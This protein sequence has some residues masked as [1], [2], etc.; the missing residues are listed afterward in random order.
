MRAHERRNDGR[1]QRQFMKERAS[2][3]PPFLV[4]TRLEGSTTSEGTRSSS[5]FA[6]RSGFFT[7]HFGL[8]H[9]FYSLP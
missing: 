7:H 6:T 1:R 9:I 3:F 4:R 2:R 8:L 5:L